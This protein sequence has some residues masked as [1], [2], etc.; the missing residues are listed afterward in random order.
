MSKRGSAKAKPFDKVFNDRKPRTGTPTAARSSVKRAVAGLTKNSAPKSAYIGKT[1]NDG[2]NEGLRA[3]YNEKYKDMGMDRITPLYTSSSQKSALKVEKQLTS[4]LKG[5]RK[6]ANEC[7]GGGGRLSST[8]KKEHC[9]YLAQKK[10]RIEGSASKGATRAR[11]TGA[12]AGARSS[13]G[14]KK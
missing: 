12:K 14:R 4:D 3:R 10:P 7:E 13:R 1:F 2:K 8:D 5:K 9:V 11:S 6:I